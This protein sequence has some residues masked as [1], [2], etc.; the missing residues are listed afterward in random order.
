MQGNKKILSVLNELLA[1]EL[2]AINQYMVHAE[3]CSNWGYERLSG[4]IK[5]TAIAE[6]GHAEKLIERVIFLA[7]A[8]DVSKLN[9]LHLGA[10]VA[11]ILENDRAAE[12]AA[13]QS[14]NAA[15]RLCSEVGDGGT[16]E[17][18]DDILEDEEGHINWSEAQLT[19]I[20]QMGIANYLATQTK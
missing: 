3:M 10:D 14:Y 1:E 8:P 16:R 5:K 4:A 7:G 19:Q 13:I 15:L 20:A 2:T 11:A 18:L 9:A 17:L 6:M 12:Q